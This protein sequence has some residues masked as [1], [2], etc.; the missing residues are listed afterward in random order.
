MSCRLQRLILRIAGVLLVVLGGL[1]LA[2]TP[3]IARFVKDA[4]ASESVDRLTPPMLLNHV[5]VGIL[6]LPLG[7]LTAFAAPHAAR[8]ERWARVVARATALTIATLPLLLI[9][10]MGTRYF[11]ALPFRIAT[12]IV[13]I[14]SA[15]LL[16]AAFWRLDP[17]RGPSEG[18]PPGGE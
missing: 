17:A 6:L 18:N 11:G 16:A 13:C 1:H 5:V 3:F 4:A 10:L 12:V 8:G 14:A 7:F 2:V 9:L 15:A